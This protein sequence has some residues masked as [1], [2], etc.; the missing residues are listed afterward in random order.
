LAI[1]PKG[2]GIPCGLH[3]RQ[4]EIL[5]ESKSLFLNAALGYKRRNTSGLISRD[6][7]R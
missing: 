1:H 2:P 6:Y 5:A 7:F 4:Q 3:D